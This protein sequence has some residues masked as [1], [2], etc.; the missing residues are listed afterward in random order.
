MVSSMAAFKL[1]GRPWVERDGACET[2]IGISHSWDETTQLLREPSRHGHTRQS[3]Q[4]VARNIIVQKP[5][6]YGT[7]LLAEPGGPE[8]EHTRSECVITPPLEF[9]GKVQISSWRPCEMAP[10]SGPSK[11]L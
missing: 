2:I 8:I 3:L 5:S 6:V 11:R 10:F 7:A 4:K 1:R 9:L